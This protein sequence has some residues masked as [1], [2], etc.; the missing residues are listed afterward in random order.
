M[1]SIFAFVYVVITYVSGA[2][3]FGYALMDDSKDKA[4]D[5]RS[6]GF[7]ISPVSVPAILVITAVSVAISNKDRQ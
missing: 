6:I 7:L 2:Y 3:L 5:L 1:F 4:P